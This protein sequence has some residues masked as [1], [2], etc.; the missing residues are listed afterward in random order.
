VF[1]TGYDLVA[2]WFIYNSRRDLEYVRSETL[3]IGR[4]YLEIGQK[5]AADLGH[6]ISPSGLRP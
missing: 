4:N 1:V 6:E 5:G 3:R 2:L